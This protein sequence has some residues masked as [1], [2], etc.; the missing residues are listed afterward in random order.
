MRYFRLD[1]AEWNRLDDLLA[2]HNRT[3]PPP[4]VASAIV[5]EAQTGEIVGVA[6]FMLAYHFEN[7]LALPG[8]G[9]SVGALHDALEAALS[10]ALAQTGGSL[11]Y[12]TNVMDEPRALEVA[13]RKGMTAMPGFVPHHK[14]IGESVS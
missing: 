14:T 4:Q 13:A 3:A 7:L 8:S 9:V 2:L 12:Y 1:P 11:T 5:A 10:P 6:F